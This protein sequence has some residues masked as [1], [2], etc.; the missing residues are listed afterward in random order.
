METPYDP[1]A[2]PTVLL[3]QQAQFLQGRIQDL[4]RQSE[5]NRDQISAFRLRTFQ[6]QK[7]LD[8]ALE[9][10]EQRDQVLRDVSNQGTAG[11]RQVIS[12]KERITNLEQQLSE[13]QTSALLITQKENELREEIVR[14]QQQYRSVLDQ[15]V[16]RVRESN[17]FLQETIQAASQIAPV[18]AEEILQLSVLINERAVQNLFCLANVLGS[19]LPIPTDSNYDSIYNAFYN[20][21]DQFAMNQVDYLMQR[22]RITFSANIDY[23]SPY[24]TEAW[25]NSIQYLYQLVYNP[26]G[27]TAT[28]TESSNVPDIVASDG[29]RP[30][31]P[32]QVFKTQVIASVVQKTRNQLYKIYRQTQTTSGTISSPETFLKQR[33]APQFVA[34]SATNELKIFTLPDQVANQFDIPDLARFSCVFCQ[35]FALNP[36]NL[37]LGGELNVMKIMCEVLSDPLVIGSVVLSQSASFSA[38]QKNAC[39]NPDD[40]KNFATLYR[41]LATQVPPWR[42]VFLESGFDSDQDIEET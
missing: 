16:A 24:R 11:Q 26:A 4:T 3:K 10:L 9:S 29:S 37:N 42:E 6:L 21:A 1:N 38:T 7:D 19:D 5:F 39:A 40:P 14:S 32:Y 17:V 35:Y 27:K 34:Y 13:S 33:F 22:Y 28:F 25:K 12:L 18:S 31:N 8:D 23:Q 30:L 41:L 20:I 2:D 15:I 36:A